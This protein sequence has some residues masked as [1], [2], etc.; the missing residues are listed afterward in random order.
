MNLPMIKVA[1]HVLRGSRVCG[2]TPRSENS[3][4]ILVRTTGNTVKMLLCI[5]MRC[6]VKSPKI[7]K[8]TSVSFVL[9]DTLI[10]EVILRIMD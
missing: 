4:V 10:T 3:N 8:L 5:D 9:L 6:I 1:I 7:P 2:K